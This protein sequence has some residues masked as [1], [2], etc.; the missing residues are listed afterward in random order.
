MVS[1]VI[2][3]VGRVE[4]LAMTLYS[5]ATQSYPVS[6]VIL[7]DEAK[8]PVSESF[9]VNQALDL[10]SLAGADVKILRRRHRRGIGAARLELAREASWNWVLMVDDDVALR[11]DCLDGL[12]EV[13]TASERAWAVPF[14]FLVNAALELDG[15]T[16]TKVSCTDVDVRKWTERYPW[17]VPYFNY[18]EIF[19]QEIEVA[20]TQAILWKKKE[21]LRDECVRVQALGRLPREDTYLTRVTGPGVFVSSARCDHFEHESQVTRG[22]WQNS[23]FY[24]IHTAIMKDPKGFV[25]LMRG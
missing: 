14:C 9:V 21:L 17:F 18:S 12:M 3:T 1:A 8:K 11:P 6:E 10:L 4:T 19:T 13:L 15:Y 24:R 20:G 22:Q 2:P 16:D 5:L 25:E 23:M 7:L